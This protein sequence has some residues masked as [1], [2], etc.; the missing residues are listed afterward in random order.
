MNPEARGVAP[1]VAF[2]PARGRHAAAGSSLK[3]KGLV[4]RAGPAVAHSPRRGRHAGSGSSLKP[5]GS[6]EG[7][8]PA[9][10]AAQLVASVAPQQAQ[11]TGTEATAAKA[12]VQATRKLRKPCLQDLPLGFKRSASARAAW[13]GRATK[14]GP[15]PMDQGVAAD[16]GP[17][18][19]PPALREPPKPLGEPCPG[20]DAA[21]VEADT[22][23]SLGLKGLNAEAAQLL[24]ECACDCT[25]KP[26][27]VQPLL[28]HC[29]SKG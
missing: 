3:P 18:T 6:T 5:K 8:T 22:I 25:P 16:T 4:E 24:F 20:T 10:A 28:L 13:E 9:Q 15:A 7:A 11:G 27:G 2:T 12:L 1:T 23:A 29:C 19:A 21:A 14:A 17:L 26:F